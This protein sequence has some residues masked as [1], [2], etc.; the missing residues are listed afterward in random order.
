MKIFISWSGKRS[1]AVAE[2][3]NEYLKRVIQAVKPFYSPEIEKGAKWGNEIDNALEGTKFGII[4]LTPDNLH[5]TWVHYEAGALSKTPD[6]KIWTFLHGLDYG[7]VP[8][9]L[10]KFQH[11][12]AERD[13]VL[14]LLKSINA[15]LSDVDLEPLAEQFLEENFNIFWGLFDQKLKEAEALSDDVQGKNKEELTPQRGEREMLGE[16]LELMQEQQRRL[17]RIEESIELNSFGHSAKAYY[18]SKHSELAFAVAI[19]IAHK[20]DISEETKI[21]SQTVFY[22]PF[23]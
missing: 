2:A 5:S 16:V 23:W 13:D 3:L 6:A 15:R 18:Q 14:K 7:D 20:N 17:E 8:P 22:N 11:T 1:R 19:Y 21:I 4:C 9:P 12:V 10:S